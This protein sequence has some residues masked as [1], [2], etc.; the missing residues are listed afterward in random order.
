MK[1]K[2]FLISI[3]NIFFI[4]NAIAEEN[5]ISFLRNFTKL[6]N[7]NN[8]SDLF[9]KSTRKRNNELKLFY[10]AD[11]QIKKIVLPKLVFEYE[12]IHFFSSGE[13]IYL[14][15][16]N[17]NKILIEFQNRKYIKLESS[18]PLSEM[19]KIITEKNSKRIEKTDDLPLIAITA[20]LIAN[21]EIDSISDNKV[22]EQPKVD[23]PSI[24]QPKVDAPSK[25]KENHDNL[26]GCDFTV[27]EEG[28]VAG[29]NISSLFC[30]ANPNDKNCLYVKKIK[31]CDFEDL[32]RNKE[33][34]VF[35]KR[36]EVFKECIIKAKNTK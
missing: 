10:E 19:A 17:D 27:M 25:N 6:V 11:P 35:C 9:L 18:V 13:I 8:Q 3:L 1:V 7:D 29:S 34:V 24:A 31:K 20:L 23:A 21:I 12:K 14:T 30:R 4:I 2:L 36:V 32:E 28:I 33:D 5:K 22:S 26:K 16:G 15:L